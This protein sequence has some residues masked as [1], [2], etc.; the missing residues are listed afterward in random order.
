ME[1]CASIVYSFTP[2]LTSCAHCAG[3]THPSN[4][5]AESLTLVTV[6]FLSHSSE[7]TVLM[8]C[9]SAT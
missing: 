5:H 7:Y 3:T 4:T 8:S 9:E 1:S 2:S 6:T